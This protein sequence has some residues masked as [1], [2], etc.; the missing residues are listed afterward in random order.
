MTKKTRKRDQLL[1]QYLKQLHNDD[2]HRPMAYKEETDIK[3]IKEVSAYYY[4][5]LAFVLRNN[6]HQSLQQT[7]NILGLPKGK[8]FKLSENYTQE[9]NTLESIQESI[10]H[11]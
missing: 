6:Y 9:F 4:A 8:I 11:G 2:W 10:T 7:A 5:Q 1:H 3:P